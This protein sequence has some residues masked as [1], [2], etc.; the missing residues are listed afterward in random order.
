MKRTYIDVAW[1]I[2]TTGYADDMFT[3]ADYISTLASHPWN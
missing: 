3:Q 2:F 1:T